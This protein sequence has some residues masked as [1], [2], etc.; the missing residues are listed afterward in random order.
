MF[1]KAEYPSRRNGICI[2]RTR[3]HMKISKQKHRL[4]TVVY[5]LLGGGGGG[6]S[7]GF[8]RGVNIALGSFVFKKTLNSV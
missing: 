7:V 6:V 5:K 1:D 4:G 2:K 8:T 3:M